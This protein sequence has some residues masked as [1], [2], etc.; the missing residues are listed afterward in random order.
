MKKCLKTISKPRNDLYSVSNHF[1]FSNIIHYS[2]DTSTLNYISKSK[3]VKVTTI[4]NLRIFKIA[5]RHKKSKYYSDKFVIY[6]DNNMGHIIYGLN[7]IQRHNFNL[8]EVSE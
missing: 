8:K 2:E 1:G 5:E 3:P 6:P 7:N 4:K